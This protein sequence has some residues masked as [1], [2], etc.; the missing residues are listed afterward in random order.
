ML[1]NTVKKVSI[2]KSSQNPNL[3]QQAYSIFCEHREKP[4]QFST[5]EK[6]LMLPN[7]I[8]ALVDSNCVAYAAVSE[9][10]GELE[11]E[12]ISVS[13][14]YRRQGI[15]D[16]LLTYII[17]QATHNRAD[18]I[19]LEVAQQNKHAQALYE[20][21]GFAL[22]TIRKDYYVL[23]NSKFDDALLMQKIL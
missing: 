7:S 11:I 14:A 13:L 17:T 23:A 5:F 6:A 18:Y 20:K 4:W 12:D 10:I 3:H 22:I 1:V 2:V 9:V 19:L 8:I 21:H 16:K 15:A